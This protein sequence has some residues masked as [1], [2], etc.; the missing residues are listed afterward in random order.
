M[1]AACPA[2]AATC[3]AVFLF[4]SVS[5]M[6]APAKSNIRTSISFPDTAARCRAGVCVTSRILEFTFTWKKDNSFQS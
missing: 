1:I 6:R 4:A 5:S 3:N 2:L